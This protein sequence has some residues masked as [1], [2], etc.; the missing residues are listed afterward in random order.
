MVLYDLI[1][2]A[3]K[4]FEIKNKL[5]HTVKQNMTIRS[6]EA[7]N[8]NIPQ[9]SDVVNSSISENSQSDTTRYSLDV[10]TSK[11]TVSEFVKELKKKY[12]AEFDVNE[13]SEQAIAAA[14]N[15]RRN[16]ATA[17]IRSC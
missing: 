9:N 4:N 6:G 16:G 15:V 7:F 12:H 10:E 13:I 3:P 1:D 14:R 5:P 17:A 11:L 8:N 2:F